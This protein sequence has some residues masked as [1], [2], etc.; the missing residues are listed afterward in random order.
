VQIFSGWVS[1]ATPPARGPFFFG[2]PR[3][4]VWGGPFSILI[5]PEDLFFPFFFFVSRA[6]GVRER[7]LN[8]FRSFSIARWF[9]FFSTRCDHHPLFPDVS[10]FLKDAPSLVSSED[11]YSVFP[12][13]R[14]AHSAVLLFEIRRF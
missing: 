9:P 11:V 8:A 6:A 4:A 3:G 13:L 12:V 5:T 10:L 14:P 2:K 1:Q 7:L